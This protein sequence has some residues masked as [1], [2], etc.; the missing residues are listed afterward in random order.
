MTTFDPRLGAATLVQ[1]GT[2][3]GGGADTADTTPPVLIGKPSEGQ[4]VDGDLVFTFNEAI[5]AGDGRLAVT[6]WGSHN[7]FSGIVNASPEITI[8]GNTLTLHLSQHLDYGMYYTIYMIGTQVTDLAGNAYSPPASMSSTISFVTALSPVAVNLTGTDSSDYL[9]GSHLNDT[10]AGGGGDDMIYGE[11]GDDALDGGAGNDHLSS[12]AG[13]D[14][15]SGG[16]DNDFMFDEGGDNTLLGGGGDDNL[17]IIHSHASLLDGGDGNDI[18]STDGYGQDTLLGG[19]GDDTL[20]VRNQPGLA[21]HAISLSGGDGNDILNFEINLGATITASGGNGADLFRFSGY[22]GKNDV[23]ITDFSA[24]LGD[25]LDLSSLLPSNL[26]EN[27]FAAGYLAAT[28]AGSDVTISYDTDGAAGTIYAPGLLVTLKNV[29][30]ASL[31]PSVFVGGLDITGNGLGLTLNGTSGPDSLTGGVFGDTIHGGDGN[32]IV[33]GGKGDDLIDGGPGD[34]TL[35]GGDGNDSLGGGDGKD[36][37]NGDDGDD[38]L[39]GGA[40]DDRLVDTTGA[41]VLH[42]GAG[43]DVLDVVNPAASAY[44]QYSTHGASTLDGGDGDDTLYAGN[45]SDLAYGGAGNDTI[46]VQLAKYAGDRQIVVDGGDGDDLIYAFDYRGGTTTIDATGGAGRDTYR[47]DANTLK[48]VALTIEDFTPGPDGD[49]LDVL[50]LLSAQPTSNPFGASGYL[51]LK[52]SGTDTLLQLD[53]DGA[54]GAGD[55]VTVAVLK[56]VAPG[57][58]TADNFPQGFHPDGSSAGWT[59]AGTDQA[60][61][62]VGSLLDDTISGGGGNDTISGG[63]GVNLIH[64]DGGDDRI[65]VTG[66]HSQLFGDDGNDSLSGSY[67]G[68]GSDTL[69]GGAG[70][71]TLFVLKG[72]NVADGGDGDDFLYS[73]GT[74]HNL[75]SG[76]AGN[77]RLTTYGGDDTVNGG[78]GDD[79]LSVLNAMTAPSQTQRHTVQLAGGAGHDNF[80]FA[81]DGTNPVD[82]TASGGADRDTY[83][84]QSLPRD[85]TITIADFQTGAGGDLVDLSRLTAGA[86]GN[87]FAAGGGVQVIQRGADSVIQVDPDRTGALGFVDVLILKDVDK[88]QLTADNFW[89]G[90][91]PNGSSTGVTLNGTDGADSLTGGILD[92]T[93]SG[94]LGNDSLDGAY[95]NDSLEGGGGNDRITDFLAGTS[96][97]P[98]YRDDDHL[99]GGD[100]DDQLSSSFGN[101]TLLGGAGSDDIF[102]SDNFG[103]SPRV[104][105]HVVA[106]GGDGAD[107]IIVSAYSP[108]TAGFSVAMTGGAGHDVFS[109]P[110]NAPGLTLTITDFQAGAGSDALSA[111]GSNLW[112]GSSPFTSGYYQFVQRGADAVLQYDPDGA[113]GSAAFHDV[114]TLQNVDKARLTADNTMGWPSTGSTKGQVITGTA[115]GDRLQGT[116]LDDTIS[117]G[118]G[119]DTI[120]GGMGNDSIDGGAGNDTIRG[121]FGSDTLAGGDGDDDIDAS[122][123]SDLALGGNGNDHLIAHEG[124]TTLDG[125]A[126]N[127]LLEVSLDF[128]WMPHQVTLLG[129]DGNDTFRVQEQTDTS[130]DAVMA[131][132]GAGRDIFDLGNGYLGYGG[133]YTVTDFQAGANGDQIALGD[134]Q[135]IP[136]LKAGD[137][138]FGDSHILL[139][140]QVGNDTWLEYDPDGSA[141]N[142]LGKVLLTLKNVQASSL[143]ADNFVQHV[144]PH[145]G[146]LAADPTPTP[147]PVVVTPPPVV[148]TPPPPPPPPVVV[149]PPPPPAVPGIVSTGGDTG[150]KLTGSANDDK[151]DGGA[152]NDILHGGA[153]A[154]LLIGGD[155]KDTA[156]YDGK[157]ENYKITHDASGW[158][159]AD[160][161]TGSVSDGSDTLQGVE[162]I[163]FADQMVALDLDGVA[164]QA[165]RIYRAAFDRVPDL[166]GLGYWIDR[167]DHEA[168][169]RDI[170]DGFAHSQEFVDMYGSAPSNADIVMRLYKNILHR[171]PD[172][173]GYQYWLDIL[174]NKQATLPWVLAFF[175]DSQENI[176]GV[177]ELIGNGIVYTPYGA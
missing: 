166:A 36:F 34:D 107:F 164:A 127:D 71:D 99:S 57:S 21:A 80:T 53:R 102:V 54:A 40:G 137:N 25:R 24:A 121:D 128:G 111:F 155:G 132:G 1:A 113:A 28:Q 87:P 56:N 69:W 106:D 19:A 38:T 37:L 154:D 55:F 42:G 49:V 114:V 158:H 68:D 89:S 5:Q 82:V 146:P 108:S 174:N 116:D 152:G 151:L 77:D 78:D 45:G 131:T 172:A 176:D 32:D 64:G 9:G 74:G 79:S 17:S 61:Y 135:F 100:G 120:V 50:W 52:A 13:N 104:N 144:D 103:L 48:S 147:P 72:D 51:R 67:L 11:G 96:T 124:R 92:D 170:A 88:G 105:D 10:I 119:S 110:V 47:L 98:G 44:P 76:G 14:T 86:A 163:A 148:V 143:T 101:D 93:L 26:K 115:A 90:F 22:T 75:L 125:G 157:L 130:T 18:V 60:D 84:V 141:T 94:G 165:Y 62:L 136:G 150:D 35:G 65:D 138:P 162:R 126:G 4:P 173:G 168:T 23:T 159:V 142:Y 153:G 123:G 27:P 171:E 134:L 133:W 15:L 122:L 161:R 156:T 167:L 39:D 58:L 175:S 140:R 85:S 91:N 8:S 73:T 118:L 2:M 70:N 33:D 97:A 177:A 31:T 30:L 29:D 145:G 160:Q 139:L 129:G 7:V 59:L 83:V 112:S 12:G 81:L 6:S 63:A 3:S 41:N 66:G 95:G 16:T 117:G 46:Y 149:T 169:L 109:I 20:S 43:N